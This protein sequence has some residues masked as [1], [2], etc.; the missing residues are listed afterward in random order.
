MRIAAYS[1]QNRMRLVIDYRTRECVPFYENGCFYDSFEHYMQ[2]ERWCK[3]RCGLPTKR[4]LQQQ[5]ESKRMER[6]CRNQPS[7]QTDEVYCD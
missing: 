4:E 2:I 5:I 7:G 3:G 6:V 1:S